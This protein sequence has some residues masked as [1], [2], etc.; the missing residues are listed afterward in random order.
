MGLQCN[1]GFDINQ[2]LIVDPVLLIGDL[3]E[4]EAFF[5]FWPLRSLEQ[6][7]AVLVENEELL[8]FVSHCIF[9][10]FSNLSQ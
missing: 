3:S 2:V 8:W 9:E 7:R 10:P 6:P 4:A 5:F 1:G